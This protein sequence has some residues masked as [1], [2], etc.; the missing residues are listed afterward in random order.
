MLLYRSLLILLI[1]FS[2]SS[3][4]DRQKKASLPI[5]GVTKTWDVEKYKLT[6]GKDVKGWA[7]V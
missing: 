5:N 6:K 1:V 2:F 3:C 7:Y 4:Y